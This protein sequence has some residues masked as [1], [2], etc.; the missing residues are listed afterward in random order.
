MLRPR[1]YL[2]VQGPNVIGWSHLEYPI[3]RTRSAAGWFQAETALE[4]LRPAFLRYRSAGDDPDKLRAYVRE[5]D[6][7]RLRLIN[8]VGGELQA[9][10]DLISEWEDGRL[11]LHVSISDSR[12]WHLVG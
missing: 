3:R 1:R 5:R 6:A 12:Y 7:L 9:Q 8:F 10:V 11:V 4:P 2:V